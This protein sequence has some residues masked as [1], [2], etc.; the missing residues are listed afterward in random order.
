MLI[1]NREVGYAVANMATTLRLDL[2]RALLATRWSY[3]VH[4]PIGTV[5]ASVALE[6]Q[7]AAEA[8]LRA[9]YILAFI[10]QAVVYAAVACLLSWQATVGAL[11]GGAL[12]ALLLNG[13]VRSGTQPAGGRPS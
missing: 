6:A 11:I 4:Q 1:A 10:V 13:L 9:T 2:I 12:I 3:Y 5:A 8:Y 7:L